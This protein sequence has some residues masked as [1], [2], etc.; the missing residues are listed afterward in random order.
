[1]V[2][3]SKEGK[4]RF[5]YFIQQGVGGPIK[6]GASYDPPARIKILQQS[7]GIGLITLGLVKEGSGIWELDLHRQFKE[8]NIRGEWFHPEDKLLTFIN[9]LFTPAPA[10]TGE[11]L[12]G[13]E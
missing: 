1:M 7:S 13:R 9:G 8:F 12:E 2:Q 11:A 4:S 10:T 3:T 6:I 5:V